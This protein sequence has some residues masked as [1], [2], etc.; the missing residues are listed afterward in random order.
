MLDEGDMF[1]VYCTSLN[2][3]DVHIRSSWRAPIGVQ[4]NPDGIRLTST[5]VIATIS[6]SSASRHHAGEYV[7]IDEAVDGRRRSRPAL[8]LVNCELSYFCK[9]LLQDYFQ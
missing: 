1:T 7:C 3:G 4:R 8:V 2:H 6:S 9:L 5:F